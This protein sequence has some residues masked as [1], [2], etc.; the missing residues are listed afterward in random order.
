MTTIT[1]PGRTIAVDPAALGIDPHRLDVLARRIRLEVE[2]G[3]L[4]SVQ[5][6][7]AKDNQLIA[8]ETV[9]AATDDQRYILQSVSR[10]I[11]AG[12]IWK[13]IGE[14]LLTPA[15]VIADVIPEFAPNGKAVITLEQVMT[16]TAGF[17]M[18]PLGYPKMLDRSA[19]LEAFSRWRLTYEPG[20]HMDFH[21]TSAAWVLSEL[22]ERLTGMALPE[23]LRIV[24]AEPLGLTIKLGV[25]IEL[26]SATVAMPIAFDRTSDEQQVDP[27]GPWFTARPEVLAACEPS[28]SIVATAADV[29]LYFQALHH[30]G[31]W[32][33]D[34]IDT[35]TR[36][37]FTGKSH[38]TYSGDE[39]FHLGLFVCRAGD[40]GSPYIPATA[41]P[42]TYG[43][44]GAPCQISFM[45]PETGVSFCFVTNGYPVADYDHS[46][47]GANR[48]RLIANL[49]GDLVA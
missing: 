41:S 45:D 39:V 28:H 1:P 30:S 16:H 24:I 26:Q 2:H 15:T 11:L 19:R 20:D 35:G 44:G 23:Y 10:P 17:P 46:R 34:A 14:G 43:M 7:V 3:P 40:P 29:A 42:S 37:W 49:A 12:A 8:F 13:L 6:A 36:E 21:L 27:W 33:A 32:S 25:P 18:A 5:W 38:D 47:A 22:V 31:L 9:G 48:A 4:P